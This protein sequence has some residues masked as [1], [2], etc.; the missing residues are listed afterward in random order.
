MIEIL[1]S[2]QNKDT[3]TKVGNVKADTYYVD[4][5]VNNYLY[6]M[7]RAIGNNIN[8]SMVEPYLVPGSQ[9]Y[10]AQKKLIV[11]LNK[12]NIQ[13]RLLEYQIT[14]MEPI[15]EGYKV[16]AYEKYLIDYNGDQKTKDFNSTY[17]VRYAGGAWALSDMLN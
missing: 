6:Q 5:S 15:E 4:Y 11:D 10:N 7:V 2:V 17:I 1:R 16:Q 12:Q 3:Q 14:S 13:E 9:L 8:F